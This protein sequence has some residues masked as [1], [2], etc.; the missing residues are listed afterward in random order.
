MA[1]ATLNSRLVR[2]FRAHQS[3]QGKAYIPSASRHYGAN[4]RDC[5]KY[6][7]YD[8]PTLHLKG[9]SESHLQVSPIAWHIGRPLL[10][11]TQ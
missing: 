6:K 3:S 7:R 8:H 9:S 2:T 4:T 5:C 10:E 11:D 1:P